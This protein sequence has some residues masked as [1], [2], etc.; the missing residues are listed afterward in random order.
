MIKKIQGL[1]LFGY[2]LV[3]TGCSNTPDASISYYL[4]K[5]TVEISVSQ[6][7][8]CLDLA[9]PV[10]V[11]IVSFTPTFS[12][13]LN[14][15][16]TINFGALDTFYST[17]STDI[18][19]S[20]DGRLEGFNSSSEGVG[21]DLITTVVTALGTSFSSESEL[22]SPVGD[23]KEACTEINRVAGEK[24]GVPLPL[25]VVL[26]SKVLLS[27]HRNIDKKVVY[28]VVFSPFKITG[29]TQEFYTSIVSAL[30]KLTFEYGEIHKIS[31]PVST[32]S[33]GGEDIKLVEPALITLNVKRNS[34]A[35]QTENEVTE[36]SS[37][38]PVPQWGTLYSIPIP[39]P[40]LFGTN[41]LNLALYETGKIKTLKYGSIN[42]TKDLGAAFSTLND[43]LRR[44][45]TEKALAIKNEA[46]VIAQQQRLIRCKT[47]PDEC[48]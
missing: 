4:P 44:T 38:I 22:F 9:K 40:P 48:K 27:K 46:D 7:V 39:K 13:D 30:G 14:N 23:T 29:Y 1:I 42:G 32:K 41:N 6:T 10:V 12:A 34:Y 45:D 26:K 17:S 18:T 47:T 2:L 11:T 43:Q 36:Y 15:K 16:H 8:R 31:P 24:S 35:S 25:S 28:D 19:L 20:K 5:T 33:K 3:L 37:V 21:S